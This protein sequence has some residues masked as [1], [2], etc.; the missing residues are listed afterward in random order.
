MATITEA[1][2]RA[3]GINLRIGGRG[4]ANLNNETTMRDAVAEVDDS[5]LWNG[6]RIQFRDPRRDPPSIT[7]NGQQ[8]WAIRTAGNPGSFGTPIVVRTHSNRTEYVLKRQAYHITENTHA[9]NVKEPIIGRVLYKIASGAGA[10]AV[11]STGPPSLNV[12][13]IVRGNRNRNSQSGPTRYYYML[14]EKAGGTFYEYIDAHANR[15]R[16][17]FKRLAQWLQVLQTYGYIHADFKGNNVL[18][19]RNN[20]LRIID[21]G[22]NQMVI[23]GVTITSKLNSVYNNGR[24]L[25]LQ[26]HFMYLFCPHARSA[27]NTTLLSYITQGF[28]KQGQNLWDRYTSTG[29]PGNYHIA[30][31]WL[32]TAPENVR[33]RPAIVLGQLGAVASDNS[34][35]FQAAPDPFTLPRA[36]AG[37]DA[38]P[39]PQRP[40]PFCAQLFGYGAAAWGGYM[41]L[42]GIVGGPV[43]ILA[44]VA[45]GAVIGQAVGGKRRTTRKVKHSTKQG[46]TRKSFLKNK[47]RI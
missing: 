33:G 47:K 45:I 29:Y 1:E 44:G 36:P 32:D 25:T 41:A 26:A 12:Y 27:D 37:P 15:L 23:N 46:R 6:D 38:P 21:Y 24:D 13:Y 39:P 5:G 19:D 14:M 30:Y 17:C 16:P 8:F 18:V 28:T 7:M 40:A 31:N 2:L 22:W 4:G 20:H 42:G 43:G 3:M 9:Q 11:F 34:P 35:A 10:D